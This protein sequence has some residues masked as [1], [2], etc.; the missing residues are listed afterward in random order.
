MARAPLAHEPARLRAAD[1][2]L[3]HGRW[4]VETRSWKKVGAI[5]SK[6]AKTLPQKE[7]RFPCRLRAIKHDHLLIGQKMLPQ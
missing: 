6:R 4:F 1:G 3:K 7:T 5:L 2:A